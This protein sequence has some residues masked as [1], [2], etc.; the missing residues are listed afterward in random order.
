MS[1][2]IC[3]LF[4]GASVVTFCELLDYVVMHCLA[5]CRRRKKGDAD[6]T[7][8]QV[9]FNHH[10]SLGSKIHFNHHDQL[11]KKMAIYE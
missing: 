2:R 1:S 3:Y 8:S 5:S 11:A 6:P 4:L 10:D 7:S 9:E